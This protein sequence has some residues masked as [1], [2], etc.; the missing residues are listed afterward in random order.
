MTNLNTIEIKFISPTNT[1]GD[2]IKLSQTRFNKTA[3]KIISWNYKYS[4]MEEIALEYI[5]NK[6]GFNEDDI[7]G[8]GTIKGS[9]II[10]T[11][12]FKFID[13]KKGL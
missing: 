8:T 11:K 4:S 9:S 7:V 10:I 1:K 12:E 2:R 5:I 3:T 13:D 6:L